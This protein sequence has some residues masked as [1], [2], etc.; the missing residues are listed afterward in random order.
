MRNLI[1]I[2]SLVF[3]AIIVTSY[4]YFANL[5]EN[6]PLRQADPEA[7]EVDEGI[8]D[9]PLDRS[10]SQPVWTFTLHAK[11]TSK[12]AVCRYDE[13][14]RFVLVQDAYHILYAISASGDKLWNAQLPGPIVGDIQQL[15]DRSLLFATADRLYLLDTDGDPF[16][17]FSLRLAQR[18]TTPGAIAIQEP[19]ASVHITVQTGSRVLSYDG[20]G[21]LLRGRNVPATNT[22]TAEADD[23]VQQADI[24][25]LPANIAANCSPLFYYGPLQPGD[26][27]YLL[28]AKDN[29]VLHCYED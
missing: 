25:T 11:P 8:S 15:E 24:E 20:R 16:P 5:R 19:S 29:G 21:N 10:G 7:V 28:C 6:D 9:A 17:G 4:F 1:V 18:A 26:S 13:N 22:R 14:S 23:P 2:T 12:P 27:N 3:V